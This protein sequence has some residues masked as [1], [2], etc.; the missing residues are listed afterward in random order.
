MPS[1]AKCRCKDDDPSSKNLI[2]KRSWRCDSLNMQLR[3]SNC[4]ARGPEESS[5]VVV[6]AHLEHHQDPVAEWRLEFFYI[7]PLHI[8][9]V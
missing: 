8:H 2:E 5:P 4:A 1:D 3:N 6:M 9:L 7:F